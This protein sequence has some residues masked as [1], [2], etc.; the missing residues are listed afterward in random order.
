MEEKKRVAIIGAGESGLV[1]AKYCK[2]N[3]L[4]PVIFDRANSLGGLWGSSQTNHTAIYPG[5][6]ANISTFTMTFSDHSHRAI[7]SIIP[8]QSTIYQYFC[9]YA[10]NF[11]LMPHL[12]LNTTVNGVRQN[13]NNKWTVESTHKDLKKSEEYDFLIIASGLHSRPIMPDNIEGMNIFKGLIMHS[14]EFTL[15]DERLRNKKVVV[16]GSSFS[17]T[18]VASH[19]VGHAKSITSVFRRPYLIANRLMPIR[20]AN[21]YN[22]K[23]IDCCLFS[24]HINELN[25]EEVR[26]H[27]SN[28][29]SRQIR[30]PPGDPLHFD[31]K[32][33]S[34][35]LA[36]S[37]F[38]V[39][40]VDQGRID[41]RRTNISRFEENCVVL[42]DG[43]TIEADVVIFGTGFRVNS[44]FFTFILKKKK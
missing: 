11:G 29:F 8:D 18:D 35:R 15:N 21:G 10:M 2:E 41:A 13:E 5:L 3:G 36:F 7:P 9:D 28:L 32:T 6:T 26:E 37:D 42:E 22:I 24:K 40:Y 43:T 27:Y 23:P 16:S 38:Y 25:P 4:L 20:T 39:D 44:N 30:R 1:A 19:L 17:A 34:P 31:L 33:E 14:S 12:R